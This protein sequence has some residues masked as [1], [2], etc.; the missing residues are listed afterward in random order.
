M[1]SAVM[2]RYFK[3]LNRAR[4]GIDL[5]NPHGQ[6]TKVVP[7]SS[8]KEANKAVSTVIVKQGAKRQE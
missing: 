5:H 4:D 1:R 6:L 7:T 8:I 2:E 3:P